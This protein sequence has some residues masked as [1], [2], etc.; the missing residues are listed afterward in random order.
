MVPR[1][2]KQRSASPFLTLCVVHFLESRGMLKD[3]PEVATDP[4]CYSAWKTRCCK[5]DIGMIDIDKHRLLMFLTQDLW[6]LHLYATHW[7]FS[8]SR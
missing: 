4:N 7:I 8:L 2:R 1:I 5:V 3:A 6:S